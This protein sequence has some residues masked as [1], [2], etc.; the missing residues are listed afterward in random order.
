MALQLGGLF[1]SAQGGLLFSVQ[2][3]WLSGPL[4]QAAHAVASVA[5]SALLRPAVWHLRRYVPALRLV[6]LPAVFSHLVEVRGS[7]LG[8]RKWV[9]HNAAALLHPPPPSTPSTKQPTT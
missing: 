8:W 6:H 3:G 2:Q 7:G 5:P 9:L 4:R 1:A